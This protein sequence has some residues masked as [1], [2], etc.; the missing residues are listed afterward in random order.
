LIENCASRRKRFAKY[1]LPL[2]H[3]DAGN[4]GLCAATPTFEQLS[5]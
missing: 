2:A 1:P 4:L 5:N 3:N